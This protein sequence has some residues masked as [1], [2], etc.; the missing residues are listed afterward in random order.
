MKR[1]I[2]MIFAAAAAAALL[3]NAA[4]TADEFKVEY[5]TAA[6]SE[7]EPEV[8]PDGMVKSYLT[9]EYVSPEQ[10]RRRPISFMIDNVKG[11]WPQSGLSM[12]D[13]YYECE[14]EADLSRICA[15]FEKYDGLAKIGPMRS[16]RDYFISLVSGLDPIYEHYGQAAYALPYLESDDVDNISGMMNYASLGFYRDG[17]FQAPHNCYSS[18]EGMQ[19][20]IEYCGYRQEYKENY[21]PMLSFVKVGESLSMDDGEEAAYVK[22]GYPN[23]DPCFLYDP[24]TGLYT[25]MQYGTVHT[26][27]EN[28]EALKVRNIILEFQNG[29]NYQDSSYLHYETSGYGKGKYITGGKA[30]DITWER[31]SFFAPVTYRLSDGSPLVLNTGKTWVNVI[32]NEQMERCR[33]GASESELSCVVSEKDM[34]E[35]AALNAAWTAS[36]KAGELPYLQEMA[37][38][39][40]DNV[41]KHNGETKVEK[42]LP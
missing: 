30:V 34:E 26:D 31:A 33:I 1:R 3:M 11:S 22:I 42:G 32:R 24:E 36:Y 14:V 19:K 41:A 21:V 40:T 29:T 20:M 12:A 10:G 38:Q 39:R 4:V 8:I 5:N 17:P 25:R 16:C 9:G 13:I 35:A 2:H 28:G 7:E 18:A 15:V 37:Q 27:L 23:N 6:V